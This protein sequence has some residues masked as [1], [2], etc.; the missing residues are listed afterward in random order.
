MVRTLWLEDVNK[1][2]EAYTANLVGQ[3]GDRTTLKRLQPR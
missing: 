1:G 3:K 2:G